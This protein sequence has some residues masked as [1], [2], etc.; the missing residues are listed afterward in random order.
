M[1]DPTRMDEVLRRGP[2]VATAVDAWKQVDAE[3]R[4]QQG[5][6][7]TARQQRNA[8]NESM[9]K[10]DKKTAEFAAAR[11]TLKALSTT[12]KTGEASLTALELDAECGCRGIR[13]GDM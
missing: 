4:R 7:D 13:P 5:E 6:L 3:R 1:L 8:A 12:I 11:D 10:L 9:A 2:D